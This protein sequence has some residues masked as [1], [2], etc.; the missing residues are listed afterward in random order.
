MRRHHLNVGPDVTNLRDMGRVA[1]VE[2]PPLDDALDPASRL[3][4]T[5]AA[6]AGYRARGVGI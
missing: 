6:G 5:R 3:A 2:T 4:G 1:A